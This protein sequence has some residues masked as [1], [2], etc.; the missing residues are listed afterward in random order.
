M[1]AQWQGYYSYRS[2]KVLGPG[3]TLDVEM[4]TIQTLPSGILATY[5]IPIASWG[6]WDQAS[7]GGQ[8][9]TV[10][11]QQI[12]QLVAGNHV[13]GGS[14]S[15]DINPTTG[16]LDDYQDLTVELRR[17]DQNLPPLQGTAHFLM[18]DFFNADTGIGGLTVGET[19]AEVVDKVFQQLVELA[20]G[21]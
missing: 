4:A 17:D 20:A 16:L 19:P 5:G 18:Q 9:L 13:V 3:L 10:I 12:E 21:A 6:G 15:Q 8:L 14:P 2:V 1:A 11:A 7:P